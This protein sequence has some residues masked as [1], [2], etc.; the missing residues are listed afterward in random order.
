MTINFQRSELLGLLGVLTP[1]M[2]GSAS[3]GIR[4]KNEMLEVF[5]YTDNGSALAR[6]TCKGAEDR[7]WMCVDGPTLQELVKLADE[8]LLEINFME[9]GLTL[10]FACSMSELRSARIGIPPEV[11][12]FGKPSSSLK[13]KDLTLLSTMTEAASTDGTR[14]SLNGIFIAA[15]DGSVKAAAA[16]G[17]ILSFA[18]IVAEKLTAKGSL[19]SVQALNRAKRAI[20]PADDEDVAI[21]FHK[22]GIAL[23]IQRGNA[24]FFFEIPRIGD[25]FPDYM[26]I[27]IGVKKAITVRVE[28]R[29]FESFL[30][31]A[32]AIEGSIY[33]QVLSGFLWMMAV[34]DENKSM[35]SVAVEP[36][37]ESV[38]MHYAVSLLKDVVK[39]CA[40]NGHITLNFPAQ[41]NA[42][43]LIES[44]ASVVAM[45]LVN[46]LKESPFK[47]LQPALI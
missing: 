3:L 22:D 28:T 40:A 19:Y 44:T 39:A 24:D 38:V 20:K 26:P 18:S 30:K 31:R 2:A 41:N 17:F 6:M 16:D 8:G 37:A 23:S 47:N 21:G 45:P 34:N 10:K 13:G 7:E 35:D 5:S 42:P 27:V 32:N 29:A 1:Y 33:M 9:T 11:V 15:E 12:K 43:M 36:Q 46:D 4:T 25:N 14:P